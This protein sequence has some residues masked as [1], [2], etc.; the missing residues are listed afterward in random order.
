MPDST[1]KYELGIIVLLSAVIL[2]MWMTKSSCNKSAAFSSF[3]HSEPKR[4]VQQHDN[5]TFSKD[6]EKNQNVHITRPP[7]SKPFGNVTVDEDSI[8]KARLMQ[9]VLP[10]LRAGRNIKEQPFY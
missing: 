1:S 9:P 2:Y 4:D 3:A 7:M 5:S 6:E 10:T 8:L